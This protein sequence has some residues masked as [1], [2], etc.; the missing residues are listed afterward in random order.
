MRESMKTDEQPIPVVAELGERF[1]ALEARAPRR[2]RRRRPTAAL[3]LALI[4]LAATAAVTGA[5]G[6]IH[7]GAPHEPPPP[8]DVPAAQT[9]VPGTA[10]VESVTSPDPDGGPP[11][12]IRVSR[13]SRGEPCFA[14]NRVLDGKL[15]T[16]SGTEFHEL[17]LTGPGSC[18]PEPAPVRYEVMQGFGQGTGGGRTL[19]GGLVSSDVDAVTVNGPDSPRKLEVSKHGAFVTAYEGVLQPRDIP[20]TVTLK[21]GTVL[22]YKAPGVPG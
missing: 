10:T 13:N 2:S 9:P 7:F 17:P 6:L 4:A 3:V 20:L 5:V 16:V 18:G 11:W 14:I 21:D 15:G 8:G 19:I 1:R 22:T 12:G